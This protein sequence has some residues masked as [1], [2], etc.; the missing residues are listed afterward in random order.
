MTLV[1][2]DDFRNR[3]AS[4]IGRN[5]EAHGNRDQYLE[6]LEAELSSKK[7]EQKRIELDTKA[8]EQRISHGDS[9]FRINVSFRIVILILAIF[10]IGYAAFSLADVISVIRDAKPD[11]TNE[12]LKF[13]VLLAVTLASSIVALLAILLKGLFA[14][15]PSGDDVPLPALIRA[16][17][18]LCRSHSKSP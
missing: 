11:E 3:A 5:E 10:F 15:S 14:K 1:M 16:I 17:I 8:V 13:M 12:N 9:D 6:S 18:E 2:D 4:N 7:L